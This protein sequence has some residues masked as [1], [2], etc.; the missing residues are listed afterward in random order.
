[1]I[2][3]SSLCHHCQVNKYSCYFHWF[4]GLLGQVK[5]DMIA[6][7]N[8]TQKRVGQRELFS[9]SAFNLNKA[10]SFPMAGAEGAIDELGILNGHSVL[11]P[12]TPSDP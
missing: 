4:C 3:E 11:T 7:I 12:H 2:E 6:R 8:Y 9:P 5:L 1:M 10:E